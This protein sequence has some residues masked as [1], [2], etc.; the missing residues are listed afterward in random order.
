MPT[1]RSVARILL[2]R[3]DLHAAAPDCGD[4]LAETPQALAG[5]RFVEVV[6]MPSQQAVDAFGD[7]MLLVHEELAARRHGRGDAASPRFEVAEACK[8]AFWA[9]H[10]I[11][12]APAQLGRERL[13]GPLD[14]E[15]RRPALARLLE[16]LRRLV[17]RRD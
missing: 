10:E 5:Q 11:E 15:D 9:V 7:R 3:F 6:V 4:D 1:P 16:Q 13:D 2:E 14:P 12:A 8:H 17:D